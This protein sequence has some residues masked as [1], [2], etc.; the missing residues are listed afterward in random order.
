ML[1]CPGGNVWRWRILAFAGL[2]ILA[3]AAMRGPA[4]ASA[5]SAPGHPS[6]LDKFSPERIVPGHWHLVRSAEA[7]H[8]EVG[9]TAGCDGLARTWQR[10]DGVAIRLLWAVCREPQIEFLTKNYAISQL[11]APAVWRDRSALG[12]NVDLVQSAPGGRIWRLWLQGDLDLAVETTCGGLTATQCADL[13]VPAARYLAAGLPG[14]PRVTVASSLFPPMS[15]LLGALILASLIFVGTNRAS[16]RSRLEKFQVK[17]SPRLHSVDA[18]A[19]ELRK[20]NRGQWW[21]KLFAVAAAIPTASAVASAA[22]GSVGG[23]AIDLAYVTVLGLVS[24][25]LLRRFRHPL[26]SRARP[27]TRGAVSGIFRIRWLLS[28]V[29]TL[30]LGLLSLLIP[31]LVLAGWVAAGLVSAEQDL[32]EILAA[33]VIAGVA[34]GYLVDRGA[35]R[36]AAYNAHEA[37]KRDGRAPF[38]YLRNFGD[39]AQKIPASRLSRRGLWQRATAF[40]NPVG[41]ARFEEVF[42]RALAR[43]GPI[44]AVGPAGGKLRGLFSAV[45]PSLGAART[46]L[47]HDAWQDQVLKWA[48]DARAVVVSAT[49]RE[50]HPGFAWE[51]EMLARTV[52]H[53][54]IILVFGTGDKSMIYRNFTSFISVAGSYPLFRDL[55][56][57]WLSDGVLILAHVPGEGWGTWHGWGAERR[58]A[59]TYTAAIGAA[60]AYLESAW[61]QPPAP[62]DPLDGVELA[63]TVT[64]ALRHAAGTVSRRG[65]VIDTKAV[66]L[67][68]MDAD[69]AGDWSRIQLNSRGREALEQFDAEDPPLL[70]VGQW[71]TTEVTGACVSALMAAVRISDQHKIYPVSPGIVVLGLI[72]DK[73]SAASQVLGI[74]DECQQEAM[75]GLIQDDLL[76]VRIN[77]L[78]SGR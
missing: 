12:A 11:K 38:L 67:A 2:V 63:E 35:R 68:L 19:R 15:G 54:R 51:L 76:G 26:L 20:A 43:N 66:L 71:G 16:K 25:V 42:T 46:T 32:S 37:M 4:S 34:G 49:P 13:A 70:P 23:I 24:G 60:M 21:G 69:R 64:I 30:F 45:A 78:W 5:I 41:N 7:V 59:W 9:T 75:A 29:V 39:D 55:V 72:E 47:P 65:R 44:I 17:A 50:I 48:C 56:T 40:L 10:R 57:G 58:T 28:L 31:L 6:I 62:P 14:K 52:R 1:T 3:I 22:K 53:G 77:D 36:L 73:L 74:D 27:G 61:S 8:L 33:F 18:A